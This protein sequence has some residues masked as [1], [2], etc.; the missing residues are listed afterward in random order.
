MRFL[1][2]SLTGL[3]LLSLTAGLLLYAGDLV[4]GAVED[5][6]S[7][8]NAGP[9]ARERVFSVNVMQAEL[10]S[11]A[12]ELVAFGEVLSRR[13]LEIRASASGPI[14]QLAENFEEGARV[15]AEELL[16]QVDP[17][18]A[19]F[20]LER[21]AN[22]LLDAEAED[23]DAVRTLTLTQDEL[24]AAEAQLALRKKAF[25][26]QQDLLARGVG[27]ASTVET[28]ELALSSARQS[29]LGSRRAEAQAEARIDQAETQLNR[30]RI[31]LA[32]AER[33]LDDTI[34]RA[35]FTGTLSDVTAVEGG[36]VS[37]NERLATLI[38]PLSL[39]VAFRVS[40][41]Q[42]V[43][44]LDDTDRLHQS[45][46]IVSL[47]VMGTDL[48]ASGVITRDAAAVGEGQTGR[49][50]FARLDGARGLKPGDFVTV[51]VKEPALDRVVRLPSM[52]LDVGGTVLVV[53][54]EDR[55][56]AIQVN[57]IRR[58]GDEVLVRGRGL[59][60]QRVVTRRTPLLGA[61]IKVKPVDA[62]AP[63]PVQNETVELSDEERLKFVTAI[64][65]SDRIPG[66]VKK[67]MLKALSQPQVP[68][69][70]VERLR[71][72]MGG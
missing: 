6:L 48:Q 27:T 69:Q 60:G 64:E 51:R 63:M 13:S 70:M 21:L 32:E 72:R 52:A 9:P 50:L 17:S 18:R 23:R 11:E 35:D 65:A 40:T 61:G 10:S 42:Y 20:A 3:F 38:D 7:R 44:L 4:R 55:L 67:R 1:R 25:D 31:A 36:L 56:Q 28:A 49:V 68:A 8:D 59:E 41:P 30:L 39:E 5:R 43:R 2:Q 45:E 15:K 33:D 54:D 26:R 19:R 34:I 71:A 16:V 37:M 62:A 22:D 14:V 58:Q 57:L 47:D 53:G 24:A 29:V 46:V 12:P 66:D